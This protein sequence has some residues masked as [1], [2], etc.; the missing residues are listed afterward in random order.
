MNFRQRINKAKGGVVKLMEILDHPPE[1]QGEAKEKT[2]SALR[3]RREAFLSAA[4]LVVKIYDWEEGESR[5]KVDPE[6]YKKTIASLI[7]KGDNVIDMMF[8]GLGSEIDKEKEDI[9]NS[10][11]AAK[12]EVPHSIDLIREE[13]KTLKGIMERT[14]DGEFTIEKNT[15]SWNMKY[16]ED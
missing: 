3:A 13:L 12:K 1:F 7:N 10:D 2:K 8:D 16:A 9:M 11:I 15:Q 4:S 6:W 14:K 5:A